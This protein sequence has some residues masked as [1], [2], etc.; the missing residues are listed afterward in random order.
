MDR[1]VDLARKYSAIE[2][3]LSAGAY[4]AAVAATIGSGGGASPLAL[5]GAVATFVIDL[6]FTTQIQL[7][8]AHDIAVLYGVP[9]NIEDPEDLLDLLRVAFGIKAA[10]L[11]REAAAKAAP[12]AARQGV[13][14]VIKGPV[15]AFLKGLPV[16]GKYLLQRNIIK[17]AIPVVGI[18]LSS[19]MNYWTTGSIGKRA[20]QIYR[21]KAAIRESASAMSAAL[22][23]EPSLLLRVLWMVTSADQRIDEREAELLRVVV[24]QLRAAGAADVALAEFESMVNLDRD[25]LLAEIRSAPDTVRQELYEAACVSAGVDR[26][27]HATEIAVLR[28]LAD[29]CGTRFDE[30]DIR[31]KAKRWAS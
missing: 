19:G 23:E 5:P 31:K 24:E 16:I 27:I 18:P 17:F 10:E 3:G 21:D 1:R 13:K 25:R 30:A 8:L 14:A 11:V 28:T 12:E 6:F 9:I 15:L 26:Q 2:G 4:T 29:A 22:S 20:K 7:R